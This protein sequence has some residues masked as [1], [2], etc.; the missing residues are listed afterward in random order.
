VRISSRPGWKTSPLARGRIHCCKA[1][2]HIIFSLARRGGPYIF[3]SRSLSAALSRCA[4]AKKPLSAGCSPPRAGAAACLPA[5]ERGLADAVPAAHLHRGCPRR[6]LVQDP[7]DLLFA[8]A[9]P[10]HGESSCH[11]GYQE[12]SPP[13]WTDSRGEAHWHFSCPGA[14]ALPNTVSAALMPIAKRG[15]GLPDG[16]RFISSCHADL[17]DCR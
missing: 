7:D 8:E 3:P 15:W 14:S 6:G 16:L 17:P 2:S 1:S 9:L 10:L 13:A 12:N 5:I 4:S 11:L